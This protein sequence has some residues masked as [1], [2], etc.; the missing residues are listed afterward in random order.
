MERKYKTVLFY[1]DEIEGHFP[2]Q[3][4]MF[5]ELYNA[6]VVYSYYEYNLFTKQYAYMIEYI[7]EI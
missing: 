7:K 6:K 4:A 3:I 5:E 1:L 2:H